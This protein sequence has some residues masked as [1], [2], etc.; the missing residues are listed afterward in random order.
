MVVVWLMGG[1]VTFLSSKL[2]KSSAYELVEGHE[3]VRGSSQLIVIINR[4]RM[5]GLPML[6]HCLFD[7]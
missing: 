5:G 7:L 4:W 2:M 3:Q 6:Q 1:E